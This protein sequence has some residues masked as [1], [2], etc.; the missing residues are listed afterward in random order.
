[1]MNNGPH[2]DSIGVLFKIVLERKIASD[3]SQKHKDNLRHL[4]E[5]FMTFL[6]TEG[7]LMPVDELT[8][9]K[10]EEFLERYNSS[11]T[12]YMN[13]R[14]ELSVLFNSAAKLIDRNLSAVKKTSTRRVR[15][16]LHQAYEA[17]QLKPVLNF[18]KG[19]HESLYLCCLLVYG[20]LLRP[21]EE[22][23][24]LTKK[25]FKAGNTEI[26]L[27]GNENK[28]GRVRVVFVPDY[29]R[30][31]LEPLLKELNRDDNIFTRQKKPFN[32]GF[33]NRQWSRV[34]K[35][36]LAHGLIYQ[37]QTI[38]SF[39]HTAAINVF[40]NSKDVYLLQRMLGHSYVV[41]TLKYLRSLGEFNKDELRASAPTL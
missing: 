38:Y 33:F 4:Y 18:I 5:H 8:P 37:N 19:H 31:E 34:K 3:L 21:H 35:V 20:C 6:G 15:A 16:K 39:R 41:I 2:S 11:G 13:K 40:R 14:R 25:H 10:L 26:H 28:G 36:L 23:R 30:E 17:Q 7:Q 9:A 32:R 24:L 12:H 22:V 1:M 29:V 27:G